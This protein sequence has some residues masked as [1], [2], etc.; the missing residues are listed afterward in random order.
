MKRISNIALVLGIGITVLMAAA[1]PKRVSIAEI[2]ANPSKYRDK[3]VAIAGV[4]SDSWG[5]N[6]PGTPSRGGADKDDD[7]T[8]SMWVITDDAVP[9]KGAE[10]VVK[11]MVSSG[12]SLG[13]RSFGLGMM[14]KDRRFRK[15]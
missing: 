3:E 10:V 14:E 12:V 2:E 6:I 11:G 8:G 4:V 13:V 9:N 1:C 15:R 5:L 7:G